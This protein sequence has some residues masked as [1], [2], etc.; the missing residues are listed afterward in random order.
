MLVAKWIFRVREKN[1]PESLTFISFCEY[2][3]IYL[4]VLS[5]M[6]FLRIGIPCNKIVIL[7]ISSLDFEEKVI[8]SALIE[9]GKLISAVVFQFEICF[10]YFQITD[11]LF[12][13]FKLCQMYW[14][15]FIVSRKDKGL[16]SKI[17]EFVKFANHFWYETTNVKFISYSC[18]QTV[19]PMWALCQC[20]NTI[21]IMVLY[22]HFSMSEQKRRAEYSLCKF[23]WI[24]L[25]HAT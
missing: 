4:L 3:S 16:L 10:Y 21:A 6:V 9:Y 2:Q 8:F 23:S 5:S 13:N 17:V 12:I 22:F 7:S 18:V 1:K 24:S 25:C 20:T 15:W 11:I 19:P 14:N